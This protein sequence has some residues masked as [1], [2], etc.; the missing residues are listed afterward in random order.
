MDHEAGWKLAMP[1]DQFVATA[2]AGIIGGN[3]QVAVRSISL[4]KDLS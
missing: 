1:A 4:L 2:Y 3:D